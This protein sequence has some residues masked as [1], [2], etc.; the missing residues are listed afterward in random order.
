MYSCGIKSESRTCT[1]SVGTYLSTAVQQ[2]QQCP[3][4]NQFLQLSS[5]SYLESFPTVHG[6]IAHAKEYGYHTE[7]QCIIQA[8]K[9]IT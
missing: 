7:A 4:L 8:I 1:S 2:Q 3:Y 6:A 5:L 9:S